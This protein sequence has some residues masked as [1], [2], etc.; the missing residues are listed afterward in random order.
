MLYRSTV[1]LDN[2]QNNKISSLW[3]LQVR[4]NH[5][6][7]SYTHIHPHPHTPTRIHKQTHTQTRTWSWISSWINTFWLSPINVIFNICDTRHLTLVNIQQFPEINNKN[8][9]RVR[10]KKKNSCVQLSLPTLILGPT[11]KM[12]KYFWWLFLYRN[13]L[14][15]ASIVE[16]S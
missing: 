9:S 4:F 8:T 11:L 5:A 16:K 7:K 6:F 14:Q 10:P 15:S 12:L 1:G 3:L 2:K 13:D